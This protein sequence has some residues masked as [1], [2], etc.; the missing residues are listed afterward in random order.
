MVHSAII[1]AHLLGAW[2][3]VVIPLL[4]HLW[5]LGLLNDHHP[6]PVPDQALHA[7]Q[8][9]GLREAAVRLVAL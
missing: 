7:V 6:Q 9:L 2:G 8:V 3:P 5:G 1:I 4:Q